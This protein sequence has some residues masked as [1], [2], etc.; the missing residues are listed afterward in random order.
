MLDVLDALAGEAAESATPVT[1]VAI[2]WTPV[3]ASATLRLVSPVVVVCS[4]TAEAI[5]V[6]NSLIRPITVEIRPIVA[7]QGFTVY[8]KYPDTWIMIPRIQGPSA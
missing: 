8:S 2:S 5:V 4:S 7:P 3:E 6:W 1:L